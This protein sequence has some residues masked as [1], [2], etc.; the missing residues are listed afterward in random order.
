[1]GGTLLLKTGVVDVLKPSVVAD[2]TGRAIDDLQKEATRL[3][4]DLR[5]PDIPFGEATMGI[6]QRED[7]G[8]IYLQG[9]IKRLQDFRKNIYDPEYLNKNKEIFQKDLERI[10]TDQIQY[11]RYIDAEL[12]SIDA[13]AAATY[14]D[15]LKAEIEKLQN[16]KFSNGEYSFSQG[17]LSST[18]NPFNDSLTRL[19][20]G[21]YEI[22]GKKYDAVRA[23]IRNNPPKKPIKA[24]DFF[25]RMEKKLSPEE[26]N[27]FA[28]LYA[29]EIK[30]TPTLEISG[31]TAYE[32]L[33]KSR[34]FS[35]ANMNFDSLNR[36]YRLRGNITF[37]EGKNLEQKIITHL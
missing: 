17:D 26:M 19:K 28:E 22:S 10:A 5:L 3:G 24:Q 21:I 8:R 12:K 32:D 9:M 16:L 31:K 34:G 27:Q 33:K 20:D 7:A 11:A 14:S 13:K 6:I 18:Y 36:L 4:I 15:S 23:S 25:S 1:M 2:K 30:R 35:L 37:K 29:T